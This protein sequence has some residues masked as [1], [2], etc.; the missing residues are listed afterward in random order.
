MKALCLKIHYKTAEK[1]LKLMKEAEKD[2]HYRVAK[3][4][5]AV[6]LNCD[7]KTSGDIANILMAP[8][9]KVSLWLSNYAKY[10]YEGLLEGYRSG[11]SCNL[12]DKQ[13]MELADIVD[14]GPVAYGFSSG[15]W[16]AV[17]IGNVIQNEFGIE[18][19]ARHVRRILHDL[20]F[21]VQRPKRVLA[22]A[23]SILQNKWI[24]YTY[25]NIKKKL[26]I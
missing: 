14:S 15:I 6:L 22:N 23:D 7:G 9:S 5:H 26:K 25:P 24:R 17:M 2:G 8:R 18:Y 20:D 3:R 12:R 4:I 16:T 13:R 19:S 10:G 1:L 11:R 21:S